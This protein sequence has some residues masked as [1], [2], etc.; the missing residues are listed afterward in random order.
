VGHEF[1]FRTKPAPGFD[2]I[3]HCRVLEMRPPTGMVW[4][5]TGG[6]IDT[7]VTF[8]LTELDRGRTRFH[9]RQLGFHGL[10]GQFARI[11]LASGTRRIYGE[12]LPAYLNQLA[13]GESSVPGCDQSGWSFLQ[14]LPR[15]R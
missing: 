6:P 13:G 8:T 4:I 1:T 15:R 3:V 7:T 10:G 14:R 5:W 11:V 9:V 2:G 12:R